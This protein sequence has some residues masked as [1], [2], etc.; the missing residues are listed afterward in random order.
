VY[1]SKSPLATNYD[2]RCICLGGFGRIK[3]ETVKSVDVQE[4]GD[5]IITYLDG[6]TETINTPY[7]LKVECLP[8]VTSE[9]AGKFL[10]VN[11]EGKWVA[12][13]VPLAEEQEGF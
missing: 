13:S 11:T 10:R 3:A 5:I 1:I 8:E 4:N 9:D 6:T 7:A 12:E 2:G